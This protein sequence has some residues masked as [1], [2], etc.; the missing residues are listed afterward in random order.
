MT[1]QRTT[2][3]ALLSNIT[4]IRRDIEKRPVREMIRDKLEALIASGVLQAGDE[5]PGEREL[6]SALSVSRVTIRGAIQA[7]AARG[8]LDVSQG[9]RTRV[10]GADLG[11]LRIGAMTAHTINSY[12]LEAVHAARLL[13]EC[14]VVRDA[15]IAMDAATLAQL[16][17]AL[18]VQS[19]TLDDPV[20]FLICDREFH[21]AIYRAS[22]NPLLADLVT[23]LYAYMME[24]R[25]RA[26]GEA[27]AIQR[28]YEDH[29]AIVEAL[30]AGDA[31]AVV[32]AFEQHLARIY[33][34][35]RQ[36]LSVGASSEVFP[37]RRGRGRHSTAA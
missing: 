4:E 10:A 3:S 21:V 24:N 23:D 34:T 12:G 32:A 17:H 5:L 2:S 28:S 25:R 1:Q 20:R 16:R 6:A 15:A 27:G 7:L 31:D 33:V 26:M 19:A 30:A 22:R 36:Q 11:P 13:I 9:S 14:A 29:V 8:I 18:D 37:P 35:T